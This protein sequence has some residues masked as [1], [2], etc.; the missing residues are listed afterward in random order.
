M[1]ICLKNTQ[2]CFYY[3]SVIRDIFMILFLFLF[4][5]SFGEIYE[6]D[7]E[8]SSPGLVWTDA[9]GIHSI[10]DV[11]SESRLSGITHPCSGTKVIK[12]AEDG[13]T[14]GIHLTLAGGEGQDMTVEAWVFCEGNDGSVSHSGYQAIVARASYQ[15]IE[16]FIRLAWDPDHSESGD[17]GDGWVKLQAY[18]GATWDYFGIDYS[19]FGSQTQ[20]YILNGTT[21]SSSWHKFK[22]VVGGNQVSAFIDDMETPQATG[23]MSIIL[24]DGQGGFYVYTSGDYAGYFDNF[25]ANVTIPP[26]TDFDVLIRNGEVY[27][28]GNSSSQLTDIGINREMISEMGDLS[29]KSAD[30]TIDASNLMVTP[31]FIDAHTHADSGGAL[32][33]YINQGVT[34]VVTGDCGS[35]PSVTNV[36]AY[37]NSLEGELGPN[38]I[39]LVGHNNLRSA[40]G[41]SGSTPTPT[42]M[43]AMK[44]YLDQALRDGAFG[45]STG[46]IYASGYNST[47]EEIIELAGVVASHKGVY[48]S[49]MRSEG[50]FLLEAVDEAIQIGHEGGCN[51][52]IS[53]IKC[54]GP[55]AWGEASQVLAKVDAA[56]AVG[57][58]VRM[59]QYPYTASQTTLDVLLPSWALDNW[60]D[61]V[62]NHRVELE[63]DVRELIYDRGG[64]ENVYII[65]GTYNHQ[66]LSEVATS[67]GKDP[68]D[69]M[70]NNIGP[71]GGSAIYFQMQEDDVQTFMAHSQ[72][73]LGSDSPT[74]D[75]PRGSSTFPRFWGHYVRD[76]G[77]FS[78]IEGVRKTSTLAA[79]QFRL[80]EQKRGILQAG[81]YADITIFGYNSI[82]DRA[83][84]DNPTLSPL[85]IK[86]V[87]VNG[88]VVVNNGV[89]QPA[90]SG[91]VLR[92]SNQTLV[93]NWYV[94]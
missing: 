54:A 90:Y 85:G 7:F 70:I 42:Q 60:S 66:Y 9:M 81:Y 19:Q 74:S 84:Y 6:D 82:I 10:I 35:S 43:T 52:Q 69:V 55:F 91:K 37:Y 51:V 27:T 2:N 89:Y 87:I 83:D 59:D 41:L 28:D 45:L 93:E 47:T 61:A 17:S 79:Q 72:L 68:E 88:G 62:T 30:V 46:L 71:G 36:G 14:A 1:V 16:N 78:K 11:T 49:H 63:E 67:L 86:Y 22:L 33:S 23:T 32:S 58:Q 4:I 65:S 39:G 3:R 76:L 20:G 40:V 24:R 34:T 50:E 38:Y 80:L 25:S 12:V 29:G 18:N 64:A 31:G 92:L 26:P 8:D 53:H 44:N 13:N 94:Y 75:H 48:A 56:N 57:D 5:P 21:W 73:M 77:I 15:G